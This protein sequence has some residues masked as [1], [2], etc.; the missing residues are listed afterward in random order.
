LRR[1]RE[2][3]APLIVQQT[4]THEDIVT[5]LDEET[6]LLEFQDD[7]EIWVKDRLS[8]HVLCF[9]I[10]DGARIDDL[11]RINLHAASAYDGSRL[12]PSARRAARAYLERSRHG[13]AR[14]GPVPDARRRSAQR[15]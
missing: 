9:P 5:L 4:P 10:A 12:I 13:A 2:L 15:I 7:R 8:G 6:F 14:N 11:H 1:L 3:K